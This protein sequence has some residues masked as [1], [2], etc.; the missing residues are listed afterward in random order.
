MIIL[1][2]KKYCPKC[3][4][5][6]KTHR[7]HCPNSA[8]QPILHECRFVSLEVCKDDTTNEHKRI[9]S[10]H[11]EPYKTDPKRAK[12]VMAKRAKQSN[13]QPIMNVPISRIRSYQQQYQEEIEEL[14]GQ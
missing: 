4:Y 13:F 6:C 2:E 5:T 3:Y 9:R 10:L 8:E 12:E 11:Q 7:T 1:P 14:A